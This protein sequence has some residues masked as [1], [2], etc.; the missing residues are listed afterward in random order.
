MPHPKKGAR[1]G[2][3]P[4]HQKLISVEPGGSAHRTPRPHDH[5]GEGQAAAPLRREAHHQGQARRS[6]RS[7]HGPEEIPNKGDRR[8][9]LRGARS[10]DGIQRA[11]GYTRLIRVG[12]RRRQRPPD[13]HRARHGKVEKKAVVKAAEKTAE[14]ATASQV[15]A[16]GRG[17]RRGCC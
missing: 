5:G 7:S 17:S 13:A 16:R 15:A 9:P 2:G 8:D 3:S 11:G 1:L 10:R 6:A 12:N 14:E 4:A